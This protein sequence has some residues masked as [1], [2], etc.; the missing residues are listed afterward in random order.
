MIKQILLVKFPST[1]E[2][3]TITRILE[4]Y[5]NTVYKVLYDNDFI[6]IP[7]VSATVKDIE[8]EILKN[9]NT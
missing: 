9:P 5:Q 6:F 7:V 3:E 4:K 8:F 2:Y 1:M